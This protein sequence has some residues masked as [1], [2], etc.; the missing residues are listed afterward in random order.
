MFKLFFGLV[1][2]LND[3]LAYDFLC[4]VYVY[5][6]MWMIFAASGAWRRERI[7]KMLEYT[8]SGIIR[9]KT[10]QAA[11]TDAIFRE[12]KAYIDLVRDMALSLP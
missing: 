12:I 2:C 6:N 10:A 8:I 3:L 9:E 11:E 7:K 1:K 5:R 4:I